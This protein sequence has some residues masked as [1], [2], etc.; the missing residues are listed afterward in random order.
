MSKRDSEDDYDTSDS[1]NCQLPKKVGPCRAMIP[2]Y[3]FDAQ[4]K[5]CRNFSYGGCQGNKNRFLSQ[6]ACEK[7]C[8]QS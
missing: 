3:F 2:L 8:L 1:K 4:A 6:A 5:A 7:L